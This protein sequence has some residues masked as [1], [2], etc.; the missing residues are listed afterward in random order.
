MEALTNIPL[1]TYSSIIV[2]LKDVIDEMI[3][4]PRRGALEAL[5][6]ASQQL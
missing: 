4:K 2:F 3:L 6:M 1:D 5:H